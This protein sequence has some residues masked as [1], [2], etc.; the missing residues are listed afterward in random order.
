MR[1]LLHVVVG[2]SAALI[3]VAARPAIVLEP[4][5]PW[6]LDYADNSC[7]LIRVFG[8]GKDT[9]KLVF[10][11]VAPRGRMTVMLLGKLDA[12]N[13]NNVLAFEPLPDVQVDSGQN[14]DAVDSSARILFWPRALGRGRWGL[15]S[16]ADAARMK[17]TDPVA[18]ER[19]SSAPP[20]VGPPRVS[21]KDHDWR[22]QTADE[23]QAEDAG[24]SARADQVDAVVLNPRRSS[25]VSLHTGPLGKAFEALEQC[26][27]DSLKD[28]GI[29]SAIEDTVAVSAHPVED[30]HKLFGAGDYPQQALRTFKQDNL[31]VW[32]NI[33]AQG[34][35]SRCRVISD[36]ASPEINNAICA[37][38]QRKERFVPA[39][40]K[41]GTAVPDFY[42]EN[43]V[44]KMQ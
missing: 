23:W 21:W 32:L 30:P 43:F 25:S 27:S 41:D 28:W 26:A 12:D 2:L 6:D 42:T 29:N 7:R 8:A 16:K 14:L 19:S 17:K 40:T 35:I 37:M 31:E 39:R 24:F 22:V 18:A 34:T 15:I 38:V 9:V 10:E 5:T 11:Q 20:D 3:S 44:F 1:M 36:F 33:D 13:D 4:T